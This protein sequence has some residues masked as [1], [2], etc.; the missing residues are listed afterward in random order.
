M[1]PPVPAEE[2]RALIPVTVSSRYGVSDTQSPFS[3]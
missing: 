3:M 1:V 2:T